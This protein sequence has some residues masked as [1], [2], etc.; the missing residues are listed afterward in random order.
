MTVIIANEETTLETEESA[1]RVSEDFLSCYCEYW[2]CILSCYCEIGPA[3]S[4]SFK[5]DF[6]SLG[7]IFSFL[8]IAISEKVEFAL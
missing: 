5:N 8:I 6:F 2:T 1:V 4:S 7:N 3:S